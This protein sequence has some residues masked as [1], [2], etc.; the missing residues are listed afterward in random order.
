Q[1][2][3]LMQAAGQE[4]PDNAPSLEINSGHPLIHRLENETDDE[5]FESLALVVLDQATLVE[6]RPLEDP[7]GFV[8]R[9]NDLLL[10]SDDPASS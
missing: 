3:E 1:M 9:M 5:T 2:R 7:A 4:V 8:Q 6:G 10:Q